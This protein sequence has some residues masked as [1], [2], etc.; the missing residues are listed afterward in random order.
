MKINDLNKN[1]FTTPEG[2]FEHLQKEILNATCNKETTTVPLHKKVRGTGLLRY[3]GYAATTA[4]VALLALSIMG[5]KDNDS[6]TTATAQQADIN[7]I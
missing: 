5:N 6:T 3:I 2:Y 7:T 4:V 1:K